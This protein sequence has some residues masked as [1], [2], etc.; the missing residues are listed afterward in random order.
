MFISKEESTIIKVNNIFK[1]A[2]EIR[3]LGPIKYYLDLEISCSR[4]GYFSI[5]QYEYIKKILK[6]NGLQG[7]KPSSV[8]IEVSYG[9]S[10]KEHN[11]LSN[12]NK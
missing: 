9:K 10:G 6:E 11:M 8:S 3:D 1:N 7:S 5:S 2:F 12:N 4:N